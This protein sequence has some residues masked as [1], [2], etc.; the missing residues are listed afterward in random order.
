MLLLEYP[1]LPLVT[2]VLTYAVLKF[3]NLVLSHLNFLGQVDNL[4]LQ[5]H[6]PSISLVVGGRVDTSVGRN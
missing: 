3:T 1:H 6:F 5:L 4:I 2:V